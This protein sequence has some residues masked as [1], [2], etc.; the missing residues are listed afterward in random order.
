MQ[1]ILVNI[2]W[3][4][5]SRATRKEVKNRELQNPLVSLYRWWARRPHTL[6]SELLNAAVLHR[7]SCISDPF[8]G[9]G[10]VAIEAASRK[11]SV[12]AQDVNP[13]AA[14]GL[15]VSLTDV[16][17]DELAEAG[18]R[19][20]NDLREVHGAQYCIQCERHK[21][22]TVLNTFRVRSMRCRKCRRRFWQFPYPML[23]LSSRSQ[24]ERHA[25]FGCR[26]CGFVSRHFHDAKS[27]R[28]S[29]CGSLLQR[30]RIATKYFSS[31]KC[32]HCLTDTGGSSPELVGWTEILVQKLC[33]SAA[34]HFDVPSGVDGKRIQ[35]QAIPERLLQPIP[36]GIETARLVGAGFRTWAD[37]YPLRQLCTLLHAATTLGAMQVSNEVRERLAL[38]VIGAAEMAGHLCRWDRFHPKV[39]ESLANHRYSFDGLAVEPNLLCSSGRGNLQHRIAKSVEAAKWLR[40]HAPKRSISYSI[41]ASTHRPPRLAK[42]ICV[43]QGSSTKQL[44]PR[45][46]VSLVLTDPPYFDSVQYGELSALFT[47]WLGS[48]GL[49]SR[50]GIFEPLL[51]A[52]PNR[53]VGRDEE[54][55]LLLLTSIFKECAR[56]LRPRGRLILTYHSRQLHAWHALGQAFWRTGFRILGLSVVRT[57]NDTDHS[58]R[59]KRGFVTDLVIE[60][61]RHKSVGRPIVGAMASNP[62]ERELL[63]IGRAIAEVGGDDYAALAASFER[64]ARRMRIGAYTL[65][66]RGPLQEPR[67]LNAHA[68]EPH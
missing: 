33:T 38:C 53:V 35:A 19:L 11:C 28:C 61:V 22:S 17:P 24:E 62:E 50:S 26:K 25:F 10:T 3:K 12:Y 60:C 52:V 14:W 65:L 9:G 63:H 46:S 66:L 16:D 59:G 2:D 15:K 13:W 30:D 20:L 51:E 44:L 29:K 23:T 55:Y 40:S 32:P 45:G 34:K 18:A 1:S 54:H 47:A 36:P 58:K 41:A 8:S 68:K 64:R 57:E 43:A 27:V 56:T 5:L 39:F 67:K 21:H 7:G 31:H 37:L 49:E 4:K 48:T 42:S 6:V